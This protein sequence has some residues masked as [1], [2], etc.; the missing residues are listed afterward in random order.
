MLDFDFEWEAAPGVVCKHLAETWA[1]LK[2][3]AGDHCITHF[4]SQRSRSVRPDVYG[5]LF[6]LARWAVDHWWSILSE[7]LIDADVLRGR[8]Q[9][10]TRFHSW[11]DRHNPLAAREGMPYPDLSIFRVDEQLLLRWR[12]DTE[13]VSTSGRFIDSGECRLEVASVEEALA[14]MVDAVIERLSGVDGDEAASLREDW[15]AVRA[16][17]ATERSLCERLAAVGVDPYSEAAEE[18]EAPLMDLEF[19]PALLRDVLATTRPAD[20]QGDA[21]VARTLLS[22]L[23]KETRPTRGAIAPL[24]LEAEDARP[25]VAGYRRAS[26]FRRR[27]GLS[28]AEPAPDLRELMSQGLGISNVRWMDPPAPRNLEGAVQGGQNGVFAAM[29]RN[30]MDDRFLLARGLHHWAF[31]TSE[32]AP[33]KFLTRAHDWQQASSR[34]FAAELLAPAKAL[35]AHLAE[36]SEWGDEERLAERFHVRP[37]VIAHQLVNHQLG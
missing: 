15:A 7:G 26:L 30:P 20:V 37:M 33:R 29:R 13:E 6:P 35:E 18:L 3:R 11:L 19:E 25:F 34:A 5:S 28:D 24:S 31:A 1:R 36:G 9:A 17:H 32:S 10:N 2:I 27:L 14:R 16:S 8:R 4:Y 21:Q 22:S 12:S 23:S